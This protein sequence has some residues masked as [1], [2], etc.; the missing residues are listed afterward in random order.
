MVAVV[1]PARAREEWAAR[2]GRDRDD[3]GVRAVCGSQCGRKS[4]A[5]CSRREVR[6]NS[7]LGA[8]LTVG[9]EEAERVAALI[10]IIVIA[11]TESDSTRRQRVATLLRWCSGAEAAVSCSTVLQ[12]PCYVSM[13]ISGRRP[14]DSQPSTNS[15]TAER[16][17]AA[18]RSGSSDR[19]RAVRR[20]TRI[21]RRVHDC[22]KETVATDCNCASYYL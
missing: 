8:R 21:H 14:S 22:A 13:R 16:A 12:T 1:A 5:L 17:A 10:V 19:T 15:K 3:D 11:R 4:P 9:V 2:G 6:S 7:H 18:D 20:I